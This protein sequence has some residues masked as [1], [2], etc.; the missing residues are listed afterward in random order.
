VIGKQGRTRVSMALPCLNK[1]KQ[2]RHTSRVEQRTKM[3]LVETLRP[4]KTFSF[5]IYLAQ[6]NHRREEASTV[7]TKMTQLVSSLRRAA[8]RHVPHRDVDQKQDPADDGERKARAES[9]RQ[10]RYRNVWRRV[11]FVDEHGERDE[12]AQGR[13]G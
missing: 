10:T 4:V 8:V 2:K 6:E 12:G 1:R 5:S 13:H 11:E 3:K 7:K 9:P